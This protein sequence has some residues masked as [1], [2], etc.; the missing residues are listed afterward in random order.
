MGAGV[1]VMTGVMGRLVEE[2]EEEE[3]ESEKL[4]VSS[5]KLRARKV[6]EICHFRTV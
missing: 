2:E 3:G 1:V 4:F 5:R 6:N